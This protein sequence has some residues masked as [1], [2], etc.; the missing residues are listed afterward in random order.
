M[1]NRSTI[2][3]A[4]SGCDVPLKTLI[5]GILL[6]RK[7]LGF[8]KLARIKAFARTGS[9]TTG[10]TAKTLH[11]TNQITAEKGLHH[12]LMNVFF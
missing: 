8:S 6:R 10:I 11:T 12:I 9:D 1:P 4:R 3:C 5:L 2:L 7:E